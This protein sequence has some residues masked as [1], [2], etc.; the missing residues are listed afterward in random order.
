MKHLLCACLF[1]FIAATNFA[2][3]FFPYEFKESKLENGLTVVLVKTPTPGQALFDD[4]S[5]K[6]KQRRV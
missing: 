1:L 6:W 3:N 4:H 2:S 5:P